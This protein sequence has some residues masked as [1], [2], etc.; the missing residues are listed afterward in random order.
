MQGNCKIC[1]YINRVYIHLTKITLSQQFSNHAFVCQLPPLTKV[2]IL[3]LAKLLIFTEVPQIQ[4]G[5]FKIGL[6]F[7]I[8][9]H[10]ILVARE[11][12]IAHLDSHCVNLRS[13]KMVLTIYI[14]FF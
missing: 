11:V 7:N 14:D 2:T 8:G 4:M 5:E 9:R 13:C 3:Y 6:S 1:K 10:R 12:C